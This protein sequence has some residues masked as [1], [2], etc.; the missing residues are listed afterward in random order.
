MCARLK[1]MPNIRVIYISISIYRS[2]SQYHS[3][4]QFDYLSILIRL[5]FAISWRG[6]R[7]LESARPSLINSRDLKKKV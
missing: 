6:D 1:N 5:Y 2:S 7:K 3:Q 4:S